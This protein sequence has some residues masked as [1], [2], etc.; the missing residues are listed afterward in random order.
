MAHQ[1]QGSAFA[2]GFEGA[3]I[4]AGRSWLRSPS[5]ERAHGSGGLQRR[6]LS[7]ERVPVR[8]DSRISENRPAGR[9]STRLTFASIFYVAQALDKPRA[10]LLCKS[11][12]FAQTSDA[13]VRS[14]RDAD[15]IRTD[16]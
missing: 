2:K 5:R 10:R 9:V 13:L 4:R 11:L 1:Q 3:P 15:V 8:A 14:C 7:I 12:N 6:H 16:R